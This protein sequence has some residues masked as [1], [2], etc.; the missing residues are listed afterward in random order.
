MPG[1]WNGIHS[2]LKICRPFGLASSNLAPGTTL[3]LKKPMRTYLNLEAAHL[4][5]L[6]EM[7]AEIEKSRDLLKSEKYVRVLVKEGLDRS[8]RVW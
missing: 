2:R 7:F 1:W 6:M 3:K 4:T 5:T 8:R